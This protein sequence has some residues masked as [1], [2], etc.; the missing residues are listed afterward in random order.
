MQPKIEF[1]VSPRIPT[2]LEPLRELAYNIWWSWEPKARA[3]FRSM[4]VG[5]WNRTNHSPV[6]V[7]QLVHQSRL[8]QLAE[9]EEFLTRLRGIHERFRAYLARDNTYGASRRQARPDSGTIAY[10]SAEFGFHESIP[11][12]SG[13]LGILSGDH[14]KAASDLGLDFLGVTLLYRHG[15]FKQ[16][17]D[18]AG[19]Q[20]AKELDQNFYHLPIQPVLASDGQPLMTSVHLLGREVHLKVW[21]MAV[22]R[23]TL[24][25]LDA[26]HAI[27]HEEDREITAQLYGGDKEVR[28]RQ[29]V[30]LGM[31]GARAIEAMGISPSVWHMNEGHSAFLSLE[32]IDR[33]MEQYGLDFDSARQAVAASNVFTTHTPVA[34][35]NDAFSAH[36]MRHYFESYCGKVGIDFDY[37]MH[38]GQEDQAVQQDFSMTILALRTSRHANGVSALHGEV[39]RG[40][41]KNVWKGIPEDEVPI[42]SVTNG[43]H[44]KTWLADEVRDLY[45]RYLGDDWEESLTDIDFWRRVIDIPAEELWETHGKLKARLVDFTREKLTAQYERNRETPATIRG[46]KNILDPEILTIGFA[47][48]FATYKRATLLFSDPERLKAILNHPERPVQFLFAG[49]AHPA[50]DGGKAF[51]QKVIEYTRQAGFAHRIAF[52]EDYDAH[53]GR[54]L[55]EGVDLWL[56]NPLRPLEASGTSG[57]KL[58]PNGGINLSVLDGWWCESY[59]GDNGWAIGEEI[60]EGTTEFQNDVDAASLYE[61]IEQRIVPLYYARPDGKLPQAWIHIMRE[62]MRTVTPVYNTS[63]MVTEYNEHFYEP[64]ATAYRELAADNCARAKELAAWKHQIRQDWPQV[65]LLDAK[66]GLEDIHGIPVGDRIPV[67][68]VVHMGQVDP[69]CLEVQ[70][71]SGEVGEITDEGILDPVITILQRQEVRPDGTALFTGEIQP[72]ES[73]AYGLNIRVIPNSRDLT[74]AH[75]MRLISW[76]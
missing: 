22:G 45:D 44:T 71:Y 53:I 58:P 74:Q 43:I 48:R 66:L 1:E 68:A 31:G 65:K 36:L 3:L 47:R 52:I 39:S 56:N 33:H 46:V 16:Q 8:E 2:A 40:M 14:C 64:A 54:R 29:E 20:Q 59:N 38:F 62:S 5:L 63:R 23:I 7:L 13:G 70:A 18:R 27:N 32:R 42:G 26:D 19:W 37:F 24:Y 67:Q 30:V 76:G 73:G 51:I 21:K 17:I 35:G 49:K 69:D 41:W 72:A 4:D 57:M 28:I 61:V 12:Y 55:Y 15:Y 25:L 11:I 50:D 9:D 6:R 10:F 75:E 60:T 34:A